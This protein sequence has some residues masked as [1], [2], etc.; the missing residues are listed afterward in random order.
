M[1]NPTTI[2]AAQRYCTQDSPTWTALE[3]Y[4]TALI[5]ERRDT[6]ESLKLTPEETTAVRGEIRAFKELLRLPET[7]TTVP[8]SDPGYHAAGNS[9]FD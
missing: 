6:L 7:V 4:L 3:R 5:E 2:A 1:I 8:Q 9:D